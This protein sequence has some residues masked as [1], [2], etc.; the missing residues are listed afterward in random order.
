MARD[1]QT[2]AATALITGASGGIGQALAEL[3]G[4][5]TPRSLLGRAGGA[6]AR[7]VK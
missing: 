4:R 2:G 6:M 7:W 1:R 3:A 5:A